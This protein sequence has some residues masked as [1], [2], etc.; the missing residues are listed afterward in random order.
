MARSPYELAKNRSRAWS[1][2]RKCARTPRIATVDLFTLPIACDCCRLRSNLS[3]RSFLPLA[4]RGRPHFPSRSQRSLCANCTEIKRQQQLDIVQNHPKHHSNQVFQI[5]INLSLSP[6]E[7]NALSNDD[8]QA[9]Q[10]LAWKIN[11][12]DGN[13]I[14]LSYDTNSLNESEKKT[15]IEE[16]IR[17]LQVI[18]N[19]RSSTIADTNTDHIDFTYRTLQRTLNILSS[20]SNHSV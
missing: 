10:M 4:R 9:G 13:T 18:L 2:S 6:D 16:T 7:Q 17:K 12:S 11:T 1:H 15:L 3:A 5:T 19:S 14:D 8:Y 20:S